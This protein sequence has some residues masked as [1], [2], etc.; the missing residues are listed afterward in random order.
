MSPVAK[1]TPS[2]GTTKSTP[3]KSLKVAQDEDEASY[4]PSDS[5]SETSYV[6][7]SASR[8]PTK[9]DVVFGKGHGKT[10]DTNT[11]LKKIILSKAPT[12][13]E[14][15]SD[16]VKRDIA[17]KILKKFRLAWPNSLF[18]V[19]EEGKKWSCIEDDYDIVTKI[20]RMMRGFKNVYASN[21]RKH[22]ALEDSSDGEESKSSSGDVSPAKQS[23]IRRS[24]V[25]RNDIPSK[26][27]TSDSNCIIS[28]K[29]D[30]NSD[31]KTYIE[32]ELNL[33]KIK[34]FNKIDQAFTLQKDDTKVDC[35]PSTTTK[36]ATSIDPTAPRHEKG[37]ADPL[38]PEKD[39]EHQQ[40]PTTKARKKSWQD[41]L[42][43]EN[44]YLRHRFSFR[45]RRI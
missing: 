28:I 19:I 32:R 7:T 30:P 9:N 10:H 26:P 6:T 27:S 25:K 36:E 41:E 8:H 40:I 33:F 5:P 31:L 34:I 43:N 3:S 13:F 16:I 38:S 11:H 42:M 21:K 17:N 22:H 44:L 23:K 2:K 14:T 45:T 24:N 12:Y 37:G 1:S 4:A 15:N 18:Y 20:M 39:N 29:P 35:P